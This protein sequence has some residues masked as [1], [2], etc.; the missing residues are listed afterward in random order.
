MAHD[1]DRPTLGADAVP[2]ARQPNQQQ[3]RYAANR[4]SQGKD[5]H[6]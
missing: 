3:C 2:G 1:L 5:N 4:V 6:E